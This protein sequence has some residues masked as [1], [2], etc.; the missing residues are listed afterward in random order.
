MSAV[1]SKIPKP[2][3]EMAIGRLSLTGVPARSRVGKEPKPSRENVF[4]P[5][6]ERR[7]VLAKPLEPE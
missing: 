2:I 3:K 1:C 7:L 6:Q 5:P 4:L